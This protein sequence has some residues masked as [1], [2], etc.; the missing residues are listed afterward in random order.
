MLN[1][2]HF[3]EP[4][5]Q[6]SAYKGFLKRQGGM[7]TIQE[8]ICSCLARHLSFQTLAFDALLRSHEC[9]TGK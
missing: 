2:L 7:L 4:A 9:L 5:N 3:Y 6:D 8:I 1:K